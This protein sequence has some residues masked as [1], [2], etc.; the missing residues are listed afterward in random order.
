MKSLVLVICLL[1]SIWTFAQA[2]PTWRSWNQPVEPFRVIGNIY[3]VG[4]RE[5]SAFL[6]TSPGG[7]ILLDGG[8][9]ESAA[10][11]RDNIRKLGFKPEDV[12]Y[13][14][15]SHAHFD[16]AAGLAQLKQWTG[17][18]VAASREDGALLARGGHGDFAWGDKLT[19]PAIAPDKII[20][21]GDTVSVGGARMMAHLTPGH[22]KGCTTWTTDAEE[23]GRRF[24]VVFLCSTSVP[25]YKL[26]HNPDYPNIVEDYRG[27]FALLKVLPCEVFLA[28]HGSMFRLSEKLAA[29]KV[30]AKRNPFIDTGEFQAFVDRSK[31]EFEEELAK[32]QGSASKDR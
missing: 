8:F 16:H 15:N 29:R 19:F 24:H 10:M 17:A 14:L 5:V 1:S 30:D 26:L 20:A 22:T 7:H 21:E 25:G 9:V 31:Q 18:R 28:P 13:L 12:K 6:I 2:N 23:N 4:A 27:T 11:I 32:Q 3:Y